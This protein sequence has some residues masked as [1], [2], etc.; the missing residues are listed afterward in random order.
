[1]I[2]LGI[3]V[4]DLITD[5]LSILA[6]GYQES[7]SD[8]NVVVYNF[9]DLVNS[10]DGIFVAECR[11]RIVSPILNLIRRNKVDR[12]KVRGSFLYL[13]TDCYH[14]RVWVCMYVSV[15]EYRKFK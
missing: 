12:F 7:L 14:L 4:L 10:V 8:E 6:M 13:T 15:T 1:M 11:K 3:P 5:H 2:K 9:V